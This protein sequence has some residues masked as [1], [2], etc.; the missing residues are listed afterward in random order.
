MQKHKI[1]Q[2]ARDQVHR[3]YVPLDSDA[4]ENGPSKAGSS[5]LSDEWVGSSLQLFHLSGRV[6]ELLAPV[7]DEQLRARKEAHSLPFQTFRI[8]VDTEFKG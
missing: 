7:R 8:Y 3:L 5:G 1:R 4:A 6:L 2:E